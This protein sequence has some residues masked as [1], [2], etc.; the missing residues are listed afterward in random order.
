MAGRAPARSNIRLT[1]PRSTGHTTALC[2]RCSSCA[3]DV[4]GDEVQITLTQDPTVP[5]TLYA[6]TD[7][8]DVA[9]RI[10]I[11]GAFDTAGLTPLVK[12]VPVTLSDNRVIFVAGNGSSGSGNFRFTAT[13]IRLPGGDELTS[14]PA[15][16]EYDVEAA[17]LLVADFAETQTGL[18]S[19]YAEI[20]DPSIS[21]AGISA[22]VRKCFDRSVW[23]SSAA[24][25]SPFF[26]GSP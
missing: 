3:S 20:I 17:P 12:D 4:E 26:L 23:F 1:T 6:Y 19:T 25:V 22:E 13:D 2:S 21:F 16:I 10:N 24:A 7:P 8:T 18:G 11:S 5:G 9:N 15:T 14:S